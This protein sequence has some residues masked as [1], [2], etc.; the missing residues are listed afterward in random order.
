MRKTYRRAS[1]SRAVHAAQ[2][3]TGND[4]NQNR[5]LQA[6]SHAVALAEARS[7]VSLAQNAAAAAQADALA[8][9]QQASKLFQGLARSEQEHELLVNRLISLQAVLHASQTS[10]ETLVERILAVSA[11]RDT[12]L[13]QLAT[14]AEGTLQS[15][16]EVHSV[17]VHAAD[18]EQQL[19]EYKLKCLQARNR[20]SAVAA[21]YNTLLTLTPNITST[22]QAI[23]Q[24]IKQRHTTKTALLMLLDTQS[25]EPAASQGWVQLRTTRQTCVGCPYHVD[26]MYG[27]LAVQSQLGISHEAMAKALHLIPSLLLAPGQVMPACCQQPSSKT[28]ARCDHTSYSHHT[29]D[30]DAWM[31]NTMNPIDYRSWQR[32]ADF[33]ISR[34]WLYVNVLWLR[35][36]ESFISLPSGIVFDIISWC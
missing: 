22:D 36:L 14:V 26:Y 4:P 9:R 15:L 31:L 18:S 25:A 34:P 2:I 27:V 23:L 10:S 11:D 13:A 19:Q 1:N 17:N 28:L 12:A 21:K 24:A 35:Y 3:T 16:T 33:L 6:T 7:Q 5:N 20:A 30:V 8:A 29:N 32:L